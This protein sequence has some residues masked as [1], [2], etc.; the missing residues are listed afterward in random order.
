[1]AT[2]ENFS[3]GTRWE[4]IV[5]Y[6]RAVRIGSHIWVSGTTATDDNGNLVG[7]GDAHAQ[8]IQTF[9][10]K[11]FRRPLEPAEQQRYEAMLRKQPDL[12]AGAQLVAEVMLQSGRASI[13]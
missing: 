3:S 13:W 2:R 9:G 1:M 8:T 7:I 6:S 4:P 5:G 12:R 10:R 11:A